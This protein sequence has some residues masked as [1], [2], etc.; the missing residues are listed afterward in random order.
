M[1]SGNF[2]LDKGYDVLNPL[3]KFRAVKLDTSGNAEP[4]DTDAEAI[5]GIPQF[6]VTAAEILR[7]KGASVRLMGISEWEAAGAVNIW[8]EVSTDNV[9]R[10]QVADSGDVVVGRCYSDP[11]TNAGDRC[12]IFL[13]AGG[14][15]KA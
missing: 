11:A 10:C 15:V 12:S 3:I 5:L 7:G 6:G 8:D 14:Y 2:V 1:A 9:G 13:Y 4:C